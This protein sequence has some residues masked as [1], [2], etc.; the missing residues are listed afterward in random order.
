M[1]ASLGIE[2]TK[3]FERCEMCGVSSNSLR[4]LWVGMLS[5]AEVK[6][7]R[8]CAYKEEFG[9][10]KRRVNKKNKVIEK[11]FNIV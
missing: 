6:I 5:G 11:Y 4:F 1:L 2:R 3:T 7:C 9:T 8:E 10:K